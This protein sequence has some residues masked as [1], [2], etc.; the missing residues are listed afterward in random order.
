LWLSH[1]ED[2]AHCCRRTTSPGFSWVSHSLRKGVASKNG[3]ENMWQN[4]QSMAAS[5]ESC[6][7]APHPIIKDMSNYAK[8]NDVNQEKY[9]EP[10]VSSFQVAWR[11][12]GHLVPSRPFP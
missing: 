9:I 8:S 6:I 7:G 1:A 10:T 12:F 5:I 11:F 3:N 2:A 4:Y